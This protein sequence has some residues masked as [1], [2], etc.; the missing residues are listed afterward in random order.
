[1]VDTERLWQGLVD[2]G[3]TM[4]RIRGWASSHVVFWALLLVG[5]V[6]F[7]GVFRDILLPFVLGG[8]FAYLLNPLADRLA[9]RGMSR[10]AAAGLIIGLLGVVIVLAGGFLAPIAAAQGQMLMAS[11]PTE[12]AKLI[13]ALERLAA[14]MLG[15]HFPSARA[16]VTKAMD[17]ARASL[18]GSAGTLATAVFDRGRA[19]FGILSVLLITPL[20][21][22]Y[23]L[24]DWHRMLDAI[25]GW[26]PRAEA[27]TIRTI[28]RDIDGSVSAFVRGQALI[29]CMLGT[30]YAIGL[31]LLGLRYGVLVGIA[32]GVAAFVP[33]VGWVV[34][35]L[36]AV[37]LAIAQFGWVL[38]PLAGIVGLMIAG[39]AIDTAVLSPRLVG[40]R[41]GLHP[42]WLIFALFAASAVLGFVGT[43]IAVPLA[44]ALRVLIGHALDAYRR[45]EVYRGDAA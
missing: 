31:S 37:A 30:L 33:V 1:M 5:L 35:T 11:L 34:G 23:L 29:C 7:V 25:D 17:D 8:L 6:A 18:T 13:A 24:L 45:S 41:L 16:A 10:A 22:F 3:N 42:V 28:A 2:R 21:A 4:S 27:P 36:T 26:L 39:L 9:G 20:V 44:A 32:T 40:E 15:D 43:L 14:D 38:W 12:L 19:L